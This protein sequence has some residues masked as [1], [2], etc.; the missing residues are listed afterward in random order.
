MTNS[1][2]WASKTGRPLDQLYDKLICMSQVI[3]VVS[4][5]WSN[6]AMSKTG[7]SHD[8]SKNVWYYGRF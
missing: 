7:N 5:Q 1:H 4:A 8:R 6:N 3:T 2:T